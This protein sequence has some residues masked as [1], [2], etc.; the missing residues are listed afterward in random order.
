MPHV[1]VAGHDPAEG[2]A[3]LLPAVRDVRFPL[4]CRLNQVRVPGRHRQTCRHSRQNRVA[5]A[6]LTTHAWRRNTLGT[7]FRA[8]FFS[9]SRTVQFISEHKWEI[10]ITGDR[11]SV[12]RGEAGK[13]RSSVSCWELNVPTLPPFGNV[14]LSQ[15]GG[16]SGAQ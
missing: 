12:C 7:I 3:P 5:A 13:G 14:S 2:H 15:E 16:D 11:T 6:A 10:D 4:L 9:S 8:G 1:S